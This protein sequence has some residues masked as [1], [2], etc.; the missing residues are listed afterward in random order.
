MKTTLNVYQMLMD[1]KSM[2]IQGFV[3]PNKLM[4]IKYIF[5]TSLSILNQP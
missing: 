1:S 2:L 3:R 4:D 5:F